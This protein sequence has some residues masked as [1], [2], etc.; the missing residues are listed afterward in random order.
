[1]I[2]ITFYLLIYVF[3][4]MWRSRD[5]IKHY[6]VCC[7]LLVIMFASYSP[8]R[9]RC[10]GCLESKNRRLN[11]ALKLHAKKHN[12]WHDFELHHHNSC[13]KVNDPV[14]KTPSLYLID[15]IWLLDKS[16]RYSRKCEC[17]L[18]GCERK[19]VLTSDRWLVCILTQ[20]K[21]TYR[22]IE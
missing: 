14:I 16:I 3:V 6:F 20:L 7:F 15:K 10:D 12:D 2:F 11:F 19:I 18:H 4:Y 17:H 8:H 1:M 13:W 9:D 5:S 21:E 22:Y